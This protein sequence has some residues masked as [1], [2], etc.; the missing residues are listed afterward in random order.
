MAMR[1]FKAV[2]CSLIVAFVA[3]C[4]LLLAIGSVDIPL[5]EVLS[6]VSGNMSS[7]E[8]WNFIILESRI[9]LIVTSALAGAALAVCGLLLQTLF[10]NP[11]ADPSILGIS[12]GSSL[13]VAIVMLMAGG[14][15]GVV[16]YGYFAT[17][18]GALIGALVVM[19]VLLAFSSAVKS[20]T[21]LL[22]IGVLI[23]Y[24][25]SSAISLLNF[26]ATQESVHSYVVWG[27]GNFT[28]V[29]LRQLPVF[30]AVVV[31]GL[32][33]SL[34]IIKPLNALLLGTRYAANL[35]VNLRLTR[36]FLLL[37]TGVLTAAVTAFCG[38]VS[39]IGLVTPH[40]SRLI[41]KTTDHLRLIPVT[42]LAGSVMAMLCV[43]LSVLPSDTGLIPINAI[44]PVI[45]V[46][47]I[48]YIILN[49]RKIFYF[50]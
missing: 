49:R 8:A 27:M 18:A 12:T 5:K 39:F 40:I 25:A 34:L 32:V 50:N 15:F 28:N 19:A 47:V 41:L 26:L 30:S 35:G 33:C 20:S 11:L 1:R 42:M 45:G 7:N 4:F 9:P 6:V 29:T 44:T 21:V 13:G 43:L 22:I 24:L 38:P 23:S 31:V 46:P 36:N 10:A 37:V 14:S 3:L 2:M 16:A 17:L 48:I